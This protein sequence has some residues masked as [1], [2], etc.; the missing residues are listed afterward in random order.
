MWCD[1][2]FQWSIVC[3]GRQQVLVVGRVHFPA[4]WGHQGLGKDS[5]L[6]EV[7]AHRLDSAWLLRSL[8][9]ACSKSRAALLACTTP[10][11]VL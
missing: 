9:F 8:A 5:I 1:G 6:H 2:C 7:E 3:L 4:I 11:G 10:S